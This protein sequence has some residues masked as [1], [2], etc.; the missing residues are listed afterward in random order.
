MT[1]PTPETPSVVSQPT[2]PSNVILH[3][4]MARAADQGDAATTAAAEI[5]ARYRGKG[6][7]A[8]LTENEL[9]I[10]AD[11]IAMGF[12]KGVVN[13]ANQ[14]LDGMLEDFRRG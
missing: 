2:L 13:G 8:A 4:A 12:L 6:F 10:V 3:P 11:L 5:L 9:S 7:F 14:M 1:S